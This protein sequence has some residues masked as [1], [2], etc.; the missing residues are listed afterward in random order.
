EKERRQAKRQRML[1]RE[2][3]YAG[4]MGRFKTDLTDYAW[5]FGPLDEADEEWYRPSQRWRRMALH[6]RARVDPRGHS[7]GQSGGHSS[8]QSGGYDSHVV[9][10]AWCAAVRAAVVC[11]R[12]GD[13]A[14]TGLLANPLLMPP[15]VTPATEHVPSQE[16]R[17][18]AHA[19]LSARTSARKTAEAPAETPAGPAERKAAKRSRRSRHEDDMEEEFVP[20]TTRPYR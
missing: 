7:S 12:D 10:R 9:P 14:P 6:P 1:E 2:K 5:Q 16:S 17:T 4:I 3:L 13:A 11:A 20:P 18:R 8:G 19:E 15:A